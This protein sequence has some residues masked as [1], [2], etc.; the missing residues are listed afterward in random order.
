MNPEILQIVFWLL[1]ATTGLIVYEL[2]ESL[3]PPYCEHCAHCQALKEME[4]ER[5]RSESQ[6]LGNGFTWHNRDDD[7]DRG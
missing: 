4:R 6:S 7:D 1:V 2:H 5:R 3:K